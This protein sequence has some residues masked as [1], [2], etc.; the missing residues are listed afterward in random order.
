MACLRHR[1]TWQERQVVHET[2]AALGLT[3][4][5]QGQNE[6][7]ATILLSQSCSMLCRPS[8]TA[9]GGKSAGVPRGC[10][11]QN[12]GAKV[13]AITLFYKMQTFVNV[14]ALKDPKERLTLGPPLTP[15]QLSV[16]CLLLSE[17]ASKSVG[18]AV[19]VLRGVGGH[20]F[21]SGLALRKAD[22]LFSF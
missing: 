16:A 13:H 20:G 18:E 8:T 3:T 6:P 12:A 15:M 1:E 2:A 21:R 10:A 22:P 11:S 9:E 19:C 17:L 4:E 7:T 14:Q 5:T